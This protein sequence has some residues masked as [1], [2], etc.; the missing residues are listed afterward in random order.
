MP[1]VSLSPSPT[2]A[3]RRADSRSQTPLGKMD[4]EFQ[5][6]IDCRYNHLLDQSHRQSLTP[7]LTTM[8]IS[9]PTFVAARDYYLNL[10]HRGNIDT[11]PQSGT[12]FETSQRKS[13]VLQVITQY[14]SAPRRHSVA[15]DSYP[16]DL[17]HMK[18]LKL[19]AL[20]IWRRGS[21]TPPSRHEGF[22]GNTS[23]S[24]PTANRERWMQKVFHDENSTP[25]HS[26]SLSPQSISTELPELL[27]KA[28]R[29]IHNPLEP[30]YLGNIPFSY[31]TNKLREWGD[32]YL[33]NTAT[34]DAFIRAIPIP[35]SNRQSP[36]PLSLHQSL[37]DFSLNDN[38]IKEEDVKMC[39]PPPTA[40]QI[41]KVKVV[42][43]CR[44]RKSFFMQKAFP[45]RKSVTSQSSR[46]SKHASPRYNL[47][48][49]HENHQ[50]KKV[51]ALRNAITEAERRPAVPIR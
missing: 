18:D 34:A 31:T 47:R 25:E 14:S 8:D 10:S 33:F 41:V 22:D 28:E 4:F 5:Q 43:Q 44:N 19:R 39:E 32:V 37:S 36:P 29:Q 27:M 2:L 46:I 12:V 42:P 3:A 49:R 1:S 21:A 16:E 48:H 40:K 6:S 38:D 51:E 50:G 7:P 26:P 15:I 45:V 30:Q 17:E 9:S 35:V 11:P 23:L 13:S 20:E 24:K